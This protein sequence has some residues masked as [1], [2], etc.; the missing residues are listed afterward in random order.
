[1]R[2][3]LAVPALVAALVTAPLASVAPADAEEPQ[4]PYGQR[5]PGPGC[6]ARGATKPTGCHTW[7]ARYEGNRT[8][9]DPDVVALGGQGEHV[10]LGGDTGGNTGAGGA[11]LVAFEAGTG[12]PLWDWSTPG[13]EKRSDEI[14]DVATTADGETVFATGHVQNEWE[15]PLSRTWAFDAETGDVLWTRTYRSA[16]PTSYPGLGGTALAVHEPTESLLL[17]NGGEPSLHALDPTTGAERW[18]AT[19]L[20]PMETRGCAGCIETSTQAGLVYVVGEKEN[21]TGTVVAAV[22]PTNGTVAWTAGGNTNLGIGPQD[23]AVSPDGTTLYSVAGWGPSAALSADS[24]DVEWKRDP[25]GAMIGGHLTSDG[26]RLVLYGEDWGRKPGPGVDIDAR[27]LGMSTANGSVEWTRSFEGRQE[28]VFDED[29][30]KEGFTLPNRGVSVVGTVTDGG[31]DGTQDVVLRSLDEST[32]ESV[33]TVRYSE[34]AELREWMPSP[35]LMDWGEG[36]DAMFVGVQT[37]RHD[38]GLGAK[39]VRYELDRFRPS[40]PLDCPQS[41][42]LPDRTGEPSP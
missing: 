29:S 12:E 42:C 24:G 30:A 14:W 38:H 35:G 13:G 37:F 20:G 33:R 5:P 34:P 18:N 7:T 32:G 26:S 21:F 36:T 10:Y 19:D 2:R 31:V 17:F 9:P 15:I 11:L 28:P 41:V 16:D 6:D 25:A 23:L 1:M 3:R 8:D 40:G 27:V 22:H 4:G 39:L